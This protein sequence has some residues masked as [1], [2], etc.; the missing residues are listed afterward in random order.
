[1]D[2]LKAQVEEIKQVSQAVIEELLNGKSE[3]I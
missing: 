3:K 1:M 2:L